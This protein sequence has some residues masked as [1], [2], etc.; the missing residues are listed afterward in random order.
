MMLDPRSIWEPLLSDIAA[1]V[2]AVIAGRFHRGLASGIVE[3]L[4]KI[5]ELRAFDT[6]ARR[7]AAFKTRSY[8]GKSRSCRGGKDTKS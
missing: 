4:G 1:T 8:S 5:A 3:M 7:A 2:P 6:I